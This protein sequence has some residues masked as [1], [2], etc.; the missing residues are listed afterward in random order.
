[1][2][3]PWKLAVGLDSGRSA[4]RFPQIQSGPFVLDLT[5]VNRRYRFAGDFAKETL[6]FLSM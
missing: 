5:A 3:P 4:A 1:M 6:K 2:A